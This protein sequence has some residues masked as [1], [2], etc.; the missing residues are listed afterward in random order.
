[1]K[2]N[3]NPLFKLKILH[4]DHISQSLSEMLKHPMYFIISS[5]GCGK[6][7]SVQ[8]YL[9]T[10]HKVRTTW[11]SFTSEDTEDIWIWVRF[12]KILRS[13]N[14]PLA[15]RLFNYGPPN[16]QADIERLARAIGEEKSEGDTV[17]VFD[18]MH[19]CESQYVHDTIRKVAMEGVEGL[20]IVIISRDYPLMNVEQLLSSGKAGIMTQKNFTFTLEETLA[21]FELNDCPLSEEEGNILYEKTNG[22]ASGLYLSLMHYKAFGDFTGMEVN[23]SLMKGAVFKRFDPVTQ[24][25]LLM[26]SKIDGFTLDQAEYITEDREIRRVLRRLTDNNCFTR[27]DEESGLYSFHSMLRRM[28]EKEFETSRVDEERI[29]SRQGDWCLMS[30]DRIGAI[31]AYTK[32]FEFERI[33]DIMCERNSSTLMNMAPRTLIRAFKKMPLSIRLSNPIGYLTYIYSYSIIV[34]V[35]SGAEMLSVAKNHYIKSPD[36]EDRSQIMGEIALIESLP[37]FNDLHAMF[38]CYERANRFFDGSRSKIF[39]SDVSI[40]FGVPLTMFLYHREPGDMKELVELVE[41]EFWIFNHIANGCGAGYEELIRAEYEYITGDLKTAEMIAYK[42]IYKAK[43]REQSEIIMSASFLLLR[44]A[45]FK[46]GTSEVNEIMQQMMLE[47][48]KK[49]KPSMLACYEFVLGFVYS[50]M[51]KNDLIPDWLVEGDVDKTTLMAPA[52]QSGH[53]IAGRILCEL[54]E[55]D[56]LARVS[57]DL[58]AIYEENHHLIGVILAK[59]YRAIAS[60]HLEGIQPAVELMKEALA[61]AEPDG[62]YVIIAENTYEVVSILEE[63]DTPFAG[64]ALEAA[65]TYIKSKARFR[66]REEE[67]DKLTKREREV[68]DLVCEG[69]TAEAIGKILF[70]S[71]STVK[72]HIAAAYSKLGV[73]KKA[74]AI[75][76]YK[77]LSRK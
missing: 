39:G 71:H 11:F 70:V 69:Y 48:E 18:D 21:F 54:G 25:S 20:H 8:E 9:R 14:A 7:T 38:Q 59:V 67:M 50:F 66:R 37:A 36:L 68:M 51:G 73:N 57:E 56:K 49:M 19:L 76:E 34:N 13:V 46:G 42:A 44:I 58:T 31:S 23:T 4:R 22:W 17:V 24:Y 30:G 75:A 28:L 74:D 72:K 5:M 33:L 2:R 61:L 29:Y 16:D 52:R 3:T 63:I 53:V 47:V 10:Q 27:Y 35:K 1:M 43:T 40:T 12:C 6:T 55:F 65:K 77:R 45:L 60:F 62:C 15:S 41:R 32:S 64:K 26:L